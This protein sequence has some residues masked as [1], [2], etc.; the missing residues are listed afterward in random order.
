MSHLERYGA[1][2]WITIAHLLIPLILATV[3]AE[4]QS[5]CPALCN[6]KWSGGKK[7]A[8]CSDKALTTIP[9]DI[10]DNVQ[11]LNMDGNY[12]KEIPKDAFSS[13]GLVSLQKISLKG[14]NIQRI[15]ENAFSKLKILTEVN[16]ASNNLTKLHPK[17]FDGNDRLHSLVLSGNQISNLMPYQFP[18]LRALKKIDLS[19]TGLKTIDKKAFMNLGDSVE[20]VSIDGNRLRNIREETFLN[21]QN[22]KH[23]QLHNNPWLCDCRLKNFRDFVVARQLS[24]N[25]RTICQ[26]PERLADRSWSQIESHDFACKPEVEIQIPK[27]LAILG[28][29]ATLECKIIGNPVPA[30]KWVLAGRI[31][32]NNSAPLHSHRTEQSY[33]IQDK[34]LA[35]GGIERNFSLTITNVNEKDLGDYSCVAINKGGMAE[36][37]VSLTL[38]DP[39]SNP[40]VFSQQLAIIIGI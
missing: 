30:V 22:L 2:G 40:I 23:L 25:S 29:N 9:T 36:R 17:T 6:C 26:E 21:L 27:V 28:E 33:V 1:G 3:R 39:R 14:C 31:I 18:P 5:K 8:D 19:N 24:S 4:F 7:T 20:S 35:E 10:H 38:T 15:H 13:L 37:N 32:Q 16:L 12:I 11:V 34:A